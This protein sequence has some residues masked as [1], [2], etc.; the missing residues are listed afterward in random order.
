MNPVLSYWPLGSNNIVEI[1]SEYI[2]TDWP[3]RTAINFSSNVLRGLYSCRTSENEAS[4]Y[5][6]DYGMSYI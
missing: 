5:I 2:R 6:V 3:L 1:D 4:H